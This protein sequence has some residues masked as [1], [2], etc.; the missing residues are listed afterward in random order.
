METTWIVLANDRRLRVFELPSSNGILHEVV[1]FLSPKGKKYIQKDFEPIQPSS[2]THG[3][4]TNADNYQVDV[5]HE[6]V[7]QE[8]LFSK[9]ISSFIERGRL[10]GCFEKM[11][12]IGSRGFLNLLRE[13]MTEKAKCIIEKEFID[14]AINFEP[15]I[16]EKYIK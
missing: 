5:E 6:L 13:N 4:S 3:Q 7:H 14:D 15:P 1:D 12:I 9:Q 16:L 2:F 8:D 11:R 10:S